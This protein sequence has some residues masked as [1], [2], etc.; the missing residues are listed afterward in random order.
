MLCRKGLPVELA[1]E[2]MALAEYEPS[3]RL[4]VPHDPFHRDNRKELVEYLKYCWQVLVR[5]DM[6]ARA[7][8]IVIP[9]VGLVTQCIVQLWACKACDGKKWYRLSWHEG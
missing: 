8:D 3:R 5:C 9:W 6:M 4:K 7:L 1:V 2:I